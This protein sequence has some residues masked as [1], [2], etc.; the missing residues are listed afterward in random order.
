MKKRELDK[1]LTSA[2]DKEIRMMPMI[3]N[4]V[5]LGGPAK[6][7]ENIFLTLKPL[8]LLALAVMT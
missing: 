3:L 7:L 5:T 8:T 6:K 4:A 2:I 1:K